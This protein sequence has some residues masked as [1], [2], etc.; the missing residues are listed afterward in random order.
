MKTNKVDQKNAAPKIDLSRAAVK[1]FK[2]YTQELT[3]ALKDIDQNE[4]VNF[5][6]LINEAREQKRRVFIVGNG[7]SASTASH[8][9]TEA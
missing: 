7:G 1:H 3:Q 2:L 5:V 8:W 6:N 4:L 9:A